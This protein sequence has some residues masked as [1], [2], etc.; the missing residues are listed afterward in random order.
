MHNL[1]ICTSSS[2]VDFAT[3]QLSLED[4]ST[5]EMKLIQNAV[6]ENCDSAETLRVE[7]ENMVRNIY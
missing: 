3:E 7:N 1:V 5:A 4:A 2:A 6:K